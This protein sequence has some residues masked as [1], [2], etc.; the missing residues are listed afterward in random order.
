MAL[1]QLRAS[2]TGP[3]GTPP[4]NNIYH[5]ACSDEDLDTV[6]AALVT[7]FETFY[8]QLN[9]WLAA[10][11]TWTIFDRVLDIEATPP[12]IYTPTPAEVEGAGT[13]EPA[14]AQLAVV[15]SWHTGQ[16]GP[17]YRGRTYVGPLDV[18]MFPGGQLSTN[19]QSGFQVAA[20][21]LLTGIQGITHVGIT[22]PALMVWS[23]KYSSGIA[24]DRATVNRRVDTQRRRN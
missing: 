15:I 14:P 13:G 5:V 19:A 18:G 7:V 4:W 9:D 21:N 24:I 6:P 11:T 17:R 23:A 2:G 22:P 1:L 3:F 16:A 20:T 12:Q 8:T 10:G